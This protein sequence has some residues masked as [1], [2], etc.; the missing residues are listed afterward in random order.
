[1]DSLNL[2]INLFKYISWDK[3][4]H[5]RMI[6]ENE[7]F[8]ASIE[9][10]NDPSDSAVPIRY[11]LGTDEQIIER[12]KYYVKL[13]HP[14]LTDS[15]VERVAWNEMRINDIKNVN[16]VNALLDKQRKLVKEK[17]GIFS[18]TSE[19]NSTLMW[20][21]YS[22]SHMGICVRF[23][24]QNFLD[25]IRND[26]VRKKLLIVWDKVNYQPQFHSLNPFEIDTND[27]VIKPLLIKSKSWDYENEYRFILFDYPNKKINI[28]DGIIDQIILGCKISPKDRESIIEVSQKK[29]L[30]LLQASLKMNSYDLEFNEVNLS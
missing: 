14:H 17:Y 11:D 20:S 5:Q 1:M 22:N 30:K 25:F 8:F 4:Y 2:P 13:D 26:C 21:H 7:I 16:R 28:P 19:N 10:L 3:V 6:Y 23:N 9:N 29:N 24:S 15:E 18:M 27:I 12:Y